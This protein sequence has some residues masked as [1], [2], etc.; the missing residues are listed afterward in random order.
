MKILCHR[1][2][3][4]NAEEKNTLDALSRAVAAGYG[5]ESDVRDYCGRL[6]ISHDIANE[7]SPALDDVLKILSSAD[8]KFCFAINIKADGLIDLL[9]NSL[10]KYFLEN[11]FVF[12]MSIPQT[13]N[14]RDAKFKFFTRQSEFEPVPTLYDDADGVWIDSFKSE[15]ISVELIKKHLS[16]GKKVCVV[17]SELHSRD[18]QGLWTL[19]KPI[20]NLDWYLC[21]ALPLEAEK[22]F[23]G[24]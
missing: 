15:W 11:Y 7:N 24:E 20:K 6:V 8:D 17:S 14:Y 23:K 12:D 18:P 21:T 2:F 16:A 4:R 1:G 3:W 19:L 9:K 13:L 5:F 22:F 10:E